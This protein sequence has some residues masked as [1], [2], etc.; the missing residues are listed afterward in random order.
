MDQ[1]PEK[2]KKN[3]SAEDQANAS[4]VSKPEAELTPEEKAELS[5]MNGISLHQRML[6]R[7]VKVGFEDLTDEERAYWNSVY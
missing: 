6:S 2:E 4:P 5:R 1:L 3:A 7:M